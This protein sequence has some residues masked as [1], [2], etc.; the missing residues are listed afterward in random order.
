MQNTV[1]LNHVPNSLPKYKKKG[2]EVYITNDDMSQIDEFINDI[3]IIFTGKIYNS[4]E[5]CKTLFIDYQSDEHTIKKAYKVYGIEETIR[6]LDGHYIFVIIDTNTESETAKI[7]VARDIIGLYPLYIHTI[8]IRLAIEKNALTLKKL[9]IIDGIIDDSLYDKYVISSE[10]MSHMNTKICRPGSYHYFSLP[11]CV[12]T[13]WKWESENQVSTLAIMPLLGMPLSLNIYMTSEIYYTTLNI[14][15]VNAVIKSVGD[16]ANVICIVNHFYGEY[17]AKVA[18]KYLINKKVKVAKKLTQNDIK[19]Q[20]TI[21]LHTGN[22]DNLFQIKHISPVIENRITRDHI[23]NHNL[24]DILR[25]YHENGNMIRFPF[26]DISWIQYYMT[27][28][29]RYRG[30]VIELIYTNYRAL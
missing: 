21:I 7:Y 27:I 24:Y 15:F 28:P 25:L 23:E 10:V 9:N 12:N 8:P 26:W 3:Y 29:V 18:K 30:E 11:S 4:R 5:I 20:D 16:A 6:I 19:E 17:M 1:Y 14:L 2:I 22:I 13:K